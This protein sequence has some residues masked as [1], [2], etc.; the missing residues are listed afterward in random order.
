[1]SPQMLSARLSCAPVDSTPSPVLYGQ[2]AEGSSGYSSRIVLML[3][4]LRRGYRAASACATAVSL[5]SPRG[6]NAMPSSRFAATAEK[7]FSPHR[8]HSA[9]R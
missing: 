8:S 3:A 2:P 4:L 9:C 1:M 6:P 5:S 7:H